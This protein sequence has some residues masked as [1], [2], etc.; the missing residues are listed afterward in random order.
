MLMLVK[1]IENA[2]VSACGRDNAMELII[3]YVTRE[4]GLHWTRKFLDSDGGFYVVH[5]I[6]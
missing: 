6:F 4:T 5:C 2:K 3:K 1:M